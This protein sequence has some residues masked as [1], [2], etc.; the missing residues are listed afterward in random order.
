MIIVI[1]IIIIVI[2]FYMRTVHDVNWIEARGE[3]H[4]NQEPL[5]FMF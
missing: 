5:S 2:I 3:E 4:V 1:I